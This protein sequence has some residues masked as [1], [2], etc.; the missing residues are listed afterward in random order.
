MYK[1]E[2]SKIFLNAQNGTKYILMQIVKIE[3]K[4]KIFL[5]QIIKK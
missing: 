4:I 2:N 1:I 3:I 5:K